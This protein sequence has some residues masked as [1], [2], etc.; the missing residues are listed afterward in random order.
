MTVD[1]ETVAQTAAFIVA[2]GVMYLAFLI[3]SL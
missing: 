2:F 3:D 1:F